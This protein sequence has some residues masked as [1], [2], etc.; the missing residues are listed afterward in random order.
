MKL[1]TK[2]RIVQ[3]FFADLAIFSWIVVTVYITVTALVVKYYF[4]L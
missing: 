3:F 1:K 4:L 2:K